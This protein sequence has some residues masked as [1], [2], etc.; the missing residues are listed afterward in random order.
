MKEIKIEIESCSQCPHFQDEEYWCNKSK[1]HVIDDE[2]IPEWCKL[3]DVE[4]FYK[5]KFTTYDTSH[6]ACGLC[7]RTSCNGSCF[8]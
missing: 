1:D 6:G 3:D 5:E 4:S 2:I 7:G 8:K